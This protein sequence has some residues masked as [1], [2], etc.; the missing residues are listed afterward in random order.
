MAFNRD[1][2]ENDNGENI[3]KALEEA[4]SPDF[5]TKN[6]GILKPNNK[7]KKARFQ[8]T[9]EPSVRKKIEKLANDNGYS[10]SSEFLNELIKNI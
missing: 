3:N 1:K 4:K 7:E 10:S 9:L 8:F 2:D 5:N 6:L